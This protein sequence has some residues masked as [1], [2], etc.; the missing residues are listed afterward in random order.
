M[1]VGGGDRVWLGGGGG[2]RERERKRERERVKQPHR[3]GRKR[4]RNDKG[5]LCGDSYGVVVKTV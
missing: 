2:E 1:V 4:T 3:K 5:E